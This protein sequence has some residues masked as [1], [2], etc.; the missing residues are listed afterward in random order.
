MSHQRLFHRSEDAASQQAILSAA[1]VHF[2]KHGVEGSKV[3]AIAQDAGFT[4]PA[5]F[6]FYRTKEALAKDLFER[7]YL[8]LYA[9]LR[10]SVQ[11]AA[12]FQTNL[13]NLLNT[14][15]SIVM[16]DVDAFLYMQDNLRIFWPKMPLQV[17]KRSILGLLEELVNQG[18]A[19]GEVSPRV[20]SRMYVTALAGFWTQ[21]A[22]L[23]F[24]G[25]L[26]RAHEAWRE[27]AH[28]VSRQLLGLSH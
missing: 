9:R 4:N 17:K 14:M 21:L 8:E 25:D 2:I 12:G 13:D 26:P 19:S 23:K 20:S 10:N 3:R 22:R 24:F 11:P 27:E 1:L 5:M 7:C 18:M 6:K 28:A 15:A 16:K